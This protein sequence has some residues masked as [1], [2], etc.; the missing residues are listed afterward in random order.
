MDRR[1]KQIIALKRL[2]STCK[3]PF[4]TCTRL[5]IPEVVVE[6]LHQLIKTW[7]VTGMVTEDHLLSPKTIM[8]DDIIIYLNMRGIRTLQLFNRNDMRTAKSICMELA[9]IDLMETGL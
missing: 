6:G 9:P 2:G 4:P 1:T 3:D 7:I 5:G 8:A